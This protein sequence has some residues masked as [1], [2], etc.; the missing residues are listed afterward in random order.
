MSKLVVS[1]QLFSSTT[2]ELKSHIT[3]ELT[4]EELDRTNMF[5]GFKS[6]CKTELLCK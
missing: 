1:R 4:P 6:L 5:S 3:Q 2:D